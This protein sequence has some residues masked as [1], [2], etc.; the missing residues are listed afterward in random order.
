MLLTATVP[1]R[2]ISVEALIGMTAAGSD[3]YGLGIVIHPE[4]VPMHGHE[5]PSRLRSDA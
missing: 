5:Q 1:G 4:L 3:A 2:V